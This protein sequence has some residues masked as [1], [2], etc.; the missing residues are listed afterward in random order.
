MKILYVMN[1]AFA[2]GNGLSASCQRT[3]QYLR[4]AGEDVRILSEAGPDGEQPEYVLPEETIP[5]F[6]GLVREQGYSFARPDDDVIREAVRWADV[7][8]LEEPFVLQIHVCRIAEEENKPL[9]ATYHLHPENLYSSI[10]LRKEPNLNNST[11][12]VWRDMVF[13]HCKIVQCPTENVRQRLERWHFQSEL[14]VISNG[15]LPAPE[16]PVSDREKST[17]VYTVITTGRYSVEKDQTTLLRAMRYSKYADRIQLI[18]AGRGPIEKTLRREADRLV[19]DGVLKLPPVFGFYDLDGLRELYARADLYIHCAVV[20]VEGLSCMEAIQTG[21]VPV[22]AE[23][24]LTATSQFALSP[25]SVYPERSAKKLAERIDYWLSDDDRRRK[26]AERY[27]GAG[28]R[29]DIRKSIEELRQ[30]YRDAVAM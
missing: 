11:M 13:D 23:G 10:H 18:L 17:D 8:H 16:L 21:L 22:I 5:V 1:N 27:R 2:K 14:R 15:M 7:V 28:A 25:E 29:Y 12:L 20:E 30:M 6:D 3:V 4:D 9:T 24:R 19:Q 26:E